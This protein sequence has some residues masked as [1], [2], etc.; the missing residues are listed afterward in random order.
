MKKETK[1]FLKPQWMIVIGFLA[2]ILLGGVLLMLP[3]AAAQGTGAL[4]PTEAF[5]SATSA[6]CVTGLTVIDVASRLSRF[7]QTVLI[8]LVQLGGLGITAFS[9]FFLMVI[10]RRISMQSDYVLMDALGTDIAD[11]LHRLLAWAI[12]MTLF[13]E[14]AGAA[15]LF[16]QYR[17]PSPHQ[18]PQGDAAYY[19]VF[20]AINGFCNAGMCLHPDSMMGFR[21]NPIVLMTLLALIILG[22]IGYL[23]ILNLVTIRFWRR[24]LKTRGRLSLHSRIVLM[25]SL[26]LTLFGAFLL[27]AFEWRN[28]LSDL[29]LADKVCCSLFHS[30]STRTAGFNVLPMDKILEPTRLISSILMFIGGSPGSAAG[31]IKT[32]TLAVLLATAISMCKSR[33]ETI[34]GSR[35]IPDSVIKESIG[36]VVIML[37]MILCGYFVLLF[38]EAP[39]LGDTASKLIFETI[40]AFA[41]VGLSVNYTPNLTTAGRWIIIICMFLGRI[42]P[43]TIAFI[44]GNREERSSYIRYPE[45][46][47]VVG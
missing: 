26:G 16:W 45:E 10:G 40:S 47:L 31:G 18:L 15:I 25:M 28:T 35:T 36:I 14:A 8:A 44:I 29:S 5:F 41:T 7:G 32:T 42:G 12:L 34:I 2:L 43:L 4:S 33:R 46:D 21:D 20:H 30:G 24:N 13:I 17:I 22:G 23:V 9:T 3:Q 39:I 11:N 37:L 1:T 27:M 38:T 19:A 6:A